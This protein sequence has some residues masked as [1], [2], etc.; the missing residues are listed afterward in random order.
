MSKKKEEY[1]V[2]P[3]EEQE[4][5]ARES[6]NEAADPTKEEELEERFDKDF[7]LKVKC[8]ISQSE[9]CLCLVACFICD[10]SPVLLALICYR[11]ASEGA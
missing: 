3:V 7:W 2:I 10:D 8:M 11:N 9:H 1:L 5:Q 6:P 4:M